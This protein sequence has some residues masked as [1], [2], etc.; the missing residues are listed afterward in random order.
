M[1]VPDVPGPRA[2]SSPTSYV[3]KVFCSQQVFMSSFKN[4]N[5]IIY[6]TKYTFIFAVMEIFYLSVCGMSSELD[7]IVECS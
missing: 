7:P 2:S 6:P 1:S 5:Y 3:S 4:D